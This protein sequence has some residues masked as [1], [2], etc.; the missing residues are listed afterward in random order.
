[1]RRKRGIDFRKLLEGDEEDIIER[2]IRRR[3]ADW[4]YINKLPPKMKAAVELFIERGD[5]RLAQKIAQ[6]NI[7]DFI[8]L[9]R[10]ANVPPF[11]TV[12]R[13]TCK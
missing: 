11:I 7:E 6:M 3:E 13:K 5:L 12:V 1:M 8:E 4:N 2:E 10:R 9:L